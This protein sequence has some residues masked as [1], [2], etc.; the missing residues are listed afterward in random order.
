MSQSELSIV[1]GAFSYTGKYIT[2]HLFAQGRRVRTLTGHPRRDHPFSDRVEVA[3]LSLDDAAKLVQSM[4][5]ATTLYNTYWIRFPHSRMTFE[6]AVANTEVLFR[7]A[8]QAG[9]RKIVHI[10][11]TG[12]SPVSSLPYYRGKGEQEAALARSGV[13]Y[14]ILRPTLIFGVGDILINNMAWL[15]RRFPVFAMPGLG[16]YRLQPVA[17]EEVAAQAVAAAATSENT[18]FDVAG[19]DIFTFE[20]LVRLIARAIGRKTKIV[21]VSPSVSLSC[22]RALGYLVGDVILTPQELEGLRRSL[23]VSSAPPTGRTRFADWLEQ[24]ADTA[25]LRYASELQRHFR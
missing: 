12:A 3:P 7:A 5:G 15:L 2:Q 20:Q 22:V 19:P 4:Q 1:T 25:G 18:T 6:K 23:L 21:H 17:A 13:S 10:S 14:A 24:N 8:K 11:V 9:V 16:D